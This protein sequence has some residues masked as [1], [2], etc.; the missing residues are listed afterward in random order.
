MCAQLLGIFIGDSC[1]HRTQ[2]NGQVTLREVRVKLSSQQRA[3][4]VLRG[5]IPSSLIL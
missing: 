1:S 2:R 4:R 3:R 5:Q